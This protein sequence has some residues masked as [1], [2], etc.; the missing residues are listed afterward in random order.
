MKQPSPIKQAFRD[1]QSR[2]LSLDWAQVRRSDSFNAIDSRSA[3]WTGREAAIGQPRPPLTATV[4]A[5]W[6]AVW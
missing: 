3:W 4:R 6:Q 2:A 5:D 1:A